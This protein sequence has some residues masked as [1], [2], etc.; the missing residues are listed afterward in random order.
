M[1]NDEGLDFAL[2]RKTGRM[3]DVTMVARGLA[4]DCVCAH[5]GALLQA[6]KG[7]KNRHHFAHYVAGRATGLCGGGRESA[8]H[9]AARQLVAGWHTIELPALLVEEAGRRASIPGRVIS[10]RSSELPDDMRGATYWGRDRVRPDVVMHAEGETIWAEIL[11]THAV[12]DPKRARLERRA[13][14]TLEFD[15]AGMHREGSWT[16]ATLE[17]ALRTDVGIRRWAYHA[18]EARLRQQLREDSEAIARPRTGM[19][20]PWIGI[21]YDHEGEAPDPRLTGC[22]ESKAMDWAPLVFDP[23]MGLIPRDPGKRL[24]FIAQVYPEPTRYELSGAVAFLRRHPHGDGSC[25]VTIGGRSPGG[26]KSA[27]DAALSEF[28][29]SAGLHCVDFAIAGTREVRGPQCHEQLDRFFSALARS[30]AAEGLPASD[31]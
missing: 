2:S 9:A 29:R 5:C 28:A 17:H 15:L 25:W 30:T 27:Y 20:V 16:L 23:A 19:E 10:I 18:D 21:A 8:L 11:V 22:A 4:C 3:V 31:L 14:S 12:G 1:K 6:K 7:R 24:A 26:R 13:I